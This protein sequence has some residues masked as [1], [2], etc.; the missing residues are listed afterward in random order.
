MYKIG[1]DIRG[2]KPKNTQKY[3][4][5]GDFLVFWMCDI[6]TP[7]LHVKMFRLMACFFFLVSD[8]LC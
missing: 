1:E 8:L 4:E 5:N 2:R 3:K 6:L 7:L